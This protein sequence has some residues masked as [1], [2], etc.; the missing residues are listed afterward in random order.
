VDGLWAL[1]PF[2]IAQYIGIGL[3]LGATAAL[4]YAP[5]AQRSLL[6]MSAREKKN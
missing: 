2:L 6:L 1:A 5:F 4:V 3:A